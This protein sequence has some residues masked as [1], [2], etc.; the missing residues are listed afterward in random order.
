M[1][2]PLK[3][4]SEFSELASERGEKIAGSVPAPGAA[5]EQ[6]HRARRSRA[7]SS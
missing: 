4:V 5:A 7:N 2:G 3:I 1:S 6:V